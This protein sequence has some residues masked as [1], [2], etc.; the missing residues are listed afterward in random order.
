VLAEAVAAAYATPI[1]QLARQQI[2]GPLGMA[3]SRLGGRPPSVPGFPDPP[4]TIGDGGLWTTLSDLTVWLSAL[5]QQRPEAP[6]AARLELP[7]TLDDFSSLD[8]GWGVRVTQTAAGRLVTHGGT[9]PGWL[10]KTVRC[11]ERHIAVAV[12][13]HD[14]D[15]QAISQFGITMA[16]RVALA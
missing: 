5:N 3:D 12:L 4:G 10:A 6:A 11:P 8:Y 2:F 14:S 7:G 15:E 9:W 1:D 13:S 16:E